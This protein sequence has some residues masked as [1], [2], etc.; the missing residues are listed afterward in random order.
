MTIIMAAVE[1]KVKVARTEVGRVVSDK[2]NKT[3]V[4][5]I[6]HAR[7]HR[8]YQKYVKKTTKIKAHDETNQ[9]KTGDTVRIR[10]CRPLAKS[11]SWT[12]DVILTQMNATQ[13]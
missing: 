6:E 10:E 13:P 1:H 12:L 2:M 7:P 5:A 9:C 3:I 4:V 11:K 8:L